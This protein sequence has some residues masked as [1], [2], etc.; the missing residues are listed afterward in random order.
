MA[1]TVCSFIFYI[2]SSGANSDN[3]HK[4]LPNHCLSSSRWENIRTGHSKAILKWLAL[5]VGSGSW[6]VT[7]D[8]P[9]VVLNSTLLTD[10]LPQKQAETPEEGQPPS[11][12]PAA[13]TSFQTFLVSNP[14][15]PQSRDKASPLSKQ[16][17]VGRE[18]QQARPVTERD[19][20]VCQ[21]LSPPKFMSTWNLRT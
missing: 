17:T 7:R 10:C 12:Y 6:A 8:R 21:K 11:N 2:S 15:L 14:H 18:G 9:S 4:E 19:A 20:M 16:E 5:I 1:R 3:K 13:R